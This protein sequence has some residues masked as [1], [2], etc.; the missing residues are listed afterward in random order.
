MWCGD[1]NWENG[2]RSHEN[3]FENIVK[4]IKNCG[5]K[6]SLKTIDLY[7]CYIGKAKASEIL[8]NHGLGAITVVDDEEI[9]PMT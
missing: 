6:N 9:Y 7:A 1:S 8:S 4:G 3:R 5:L 2:W